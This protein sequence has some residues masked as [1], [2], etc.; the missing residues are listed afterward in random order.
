MSRVPA[1]AL[2]STVVIDTGSGYTKMGFSGNLEPSFTMKTQVMHKPDSTRGGALSDLDFYL[3]E[4]PRAGNDYATVLPVQHGRVQD[5]NIMERAWHRCVYQYLRC[6]P[7]EHAFLMTESPLS[8]PEDREAT[9]E[10]FFETFSAPYLYIA[11]Q[12]VLSLAASSLLATGNLPK[13]DTI[14]GVSVES[15]DGV[16][17]I[18]PVAYGYTIGSA[19]RTIPVA[20]KDV[21]RFIFQMLRDRGEKVP[22]DMAMYTAQYIKEK[23]CYC[24]SSGMV[25][26]YKKFD[27]TPAKFENITVTHPITGRSATLDVGYEQFLGPE[28]FFNPEIFHHK[29]TKS[30]P[31]LVDEAI[32]ASPMDTRRA[33][34]K[35]IVLSGGNTVFKKLATR[36]QK[37]INKRV[38]GRLSANRKKL[39]SHATAVT[40][41][42]VEVKKQKQFQKYAVWVGGSL[43]AYQGSFVRS[44]MSKQEYD[45]EGPRIARRATSR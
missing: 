24:A 35:N 18:V 34:Y 30:I 41:L 6:D 12:A 28:M 23:Y 19:V 25:K 2:K 1:H 45:E 36:L 16:T 15:G 31:E 21:T 9:A 43:L 40:P 11:N 38:Q 44:C 37:N 39:G 3:G 5:W 26:E 29:Y 17:S 32:L 20:G 7:A 14:T 8:T 22:A 4:D 42:E 27:T 33:L 13:L 10:I